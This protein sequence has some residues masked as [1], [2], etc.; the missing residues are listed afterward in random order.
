MGYFNYHAKAKNKIKQ[1]LLS[2]YEIVDNWKG[3]SPALIL[4]FVDGENIPIRQHKWADYYLLIDKSF[5]EI[6]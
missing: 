1:G 5:N 6:E 2:N 4:R 3:I